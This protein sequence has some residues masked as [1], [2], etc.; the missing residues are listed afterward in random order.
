MAEKLKVELQDENGNIYYL[1]TDAS[2]VFC[3]DGKTVESKLALTVNESDIVNNATTAATDKVVSAAVAKNLQDQISGLNTKSTGE[4]YYHG[5]WRINSSSLVKDAHGKVSLVLELTIAEAIA[6][7][8]TYNP[9]KIMTSGFLP[10]Q[11]ICGTGTSGGMYPITFK[12]G[13]N[14]EIFINHFKE[15]AFAS[16][17]TY[18][19]F[20]E[21]YV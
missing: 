10:T 18:S 12:I 20:A 4:I 8:Y 19:L 3:E 1:H 17:E 21:W 16:G 7:N 5:N 13:T 15:S 11:T 9:A 6:G 14:G 2:V